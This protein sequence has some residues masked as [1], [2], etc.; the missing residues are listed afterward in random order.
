MPPFRL[1]GRLFYAY[2]LKFVNKILI[3]FKNESLF[4]KYIMD[5]PI[6]CLYHI[7]FQNL[8]IIIKKFDNIE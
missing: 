3:Y 6:H 4:I 7:I 8:D 1:Q 5:V 2:N